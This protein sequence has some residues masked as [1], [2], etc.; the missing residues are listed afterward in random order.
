V[1]PEIERIPFARIYDA[2]SRTFL[3]E[4]KNLPFNIDFA[5]RLPQSIESDP[6]R[7]QQ[8][9]KKLSVAA[10][11]TFGMIVHELATNTA[12]YGALSNDS[13]RV[14]ICWGVNGEFTLSWTE[15]GA[16]TLCRPAAAA[17]ARRS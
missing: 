9:L 17:L 10:A 3:A 15:R 13:G 2:I 11:Q 1:T 4:A 8:V 14:E 12:K 16:R 7:L 5:Q 6:K